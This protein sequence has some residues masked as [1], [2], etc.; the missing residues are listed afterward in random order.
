[1]NILIVEDEIP[2]AEKL[3]AALER[4]ALTV[5]VT[6]M[7]NSL[8]NAVD[9]LQANPHPDL[10]LMDI[11]LGDGQSFRLFD[12]VRIDCPVIFCTAYDNYWQE[13]FEYNS[14]DY[15]LKPVSQEKLDAALRKYESLKQHFAASLEQLQRWRQQPPAFKKRFLIKRGADYFSL[16][17]EDIAW[18]YATH[19]LVCLVDNEGQKHLLD[20]SLAELEKDLDPAQFFRLN[21]KYLANINA[22]RKLRSQ[23]KGKLLVELEPAASEEVVVSSEQSAGFRQ[24]MDG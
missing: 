21:R 17:S 9:W 16:R 11:E 24:W 2:A 20:K 5:T 4:S 6:G 10:I 3:V 19:K 12:L 8:R 14:I 22:I 1:M 15:L 13:A 23:G 18:A 7:V